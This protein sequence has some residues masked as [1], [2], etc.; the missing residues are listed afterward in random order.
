M[1]CAA[2]HPAL[3][4]A[5]LGGDAA[6]VAAVG[7]ARLADR[8]DAVHARP[9]DPVRAAERGDRT[10]DVL[11]GPQAGDEAAA[12][13]ATGRGEEGEVGLGIGG[14]LEPGVGRRRRR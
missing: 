14:R 3:V 6:D 10:A 9:D 11:V 4:D 12:A 8:A 1:T 13:A 2:G 5:D 7:E